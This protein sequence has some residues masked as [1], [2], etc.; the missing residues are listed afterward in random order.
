VRLACLAAGAAQ[1]PQPLYVYRQSGFR[2]HRD[3]LW[4]FAPG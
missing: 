2:A 3:G 4:G 1:I